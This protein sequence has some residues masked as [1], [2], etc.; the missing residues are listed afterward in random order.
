MEHPVRNAF[1]GAG[2]TLVLFVQEGTSLHNTLY[3]RPGCRRCNI[4]KT[5]LL[6]VSKKFLKIF[7]KSVTKRLLWW[8]Y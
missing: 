6:K 5:L 2:I 8:L 4:I 1:I 7:K 3:R